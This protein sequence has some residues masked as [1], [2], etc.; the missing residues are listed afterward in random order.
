MKIKKYKKVEEGGLSRLWQHTTQDGRS[1]AIIGSQDKDTK[2]DRFKELTAKVKAVAKDG[3]GYKKVRGQYTYDDGTPGSEDSY[4]IYNIPKELALQIARDLNQESII[5]KDDNFFGFLT[6]DGKPDGEFTKSKRNMTL[7]PDS[8]KDFSSRFNQGRD[9]EKPF[10]FKMEEDVLEEQRPNNH[11]T[12]MEDL[13]ITGDIDELNYKIEKLIDRIKGSQEDSINLTTKVDG[14]P[15][16]ICW[17]KFDGYPD[18]SICLKSFLSKSGGINN[19]LSSAEDIQAKYGDKPDMAQ[20]LMYSLMLAKFIPEGQAWQGDCLYTHDELEEVEIDGIKY[21][22]F[23]PNTIVYAVSEDNP[24]YD[25]IKNSD[26][27]ICFHTIYT[28]NIEH[29]SQSFNVNALKLSDVPNNIYIM[30]PAL[31]IPKE[32]E[33][34]NLDKIETLFELLKKSEQKLIHNSAYEDLI[35]NSVFMNYWNTFENKNIAD[36]RSTT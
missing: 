33:K 12:H 23:K 17:S 32:A 21:L 15:A 22:T 2:E 13:I 26:F 30:S 1:F 35:H 29:K 5:W 9:S 16:V 6:A 24:S 36:K 19:C 10:N 7:D 14:A 27:G 4:I 28:G 25:T 31:T 20:K 18:D 11:Q 8:V 3:I 34:Y